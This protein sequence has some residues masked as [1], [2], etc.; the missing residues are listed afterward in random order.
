MVSS[1]CLPL[2]WTHTVYLLFI[3]LTE[4]SVL[5][6]TFSCS[7]PSFPYLAITAK[8]HVLYMARLLFMPDG[9]LSVCWLLRTRNSDRNG[10][11]VIFKTLYLVVTARLG[12]DRVEHELEYLASLHINCKLN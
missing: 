6:S 7:T 1:K 9:L 2:L 12:N 4:N 10:S 11:L 3:Y 5:M 8:C